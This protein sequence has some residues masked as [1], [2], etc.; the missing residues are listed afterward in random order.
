MHL[1]LAAGLL[2][3]GED[4]D[5]AR[6]ALT[7]ALTALDRY[8]ADRACS[9]LVKLN[10][11]RS[12]DVLIAA[13]R[14]GVLQL[15]EFE[16]ERTRLR[17][18]LEKAEPVKDKDGKILKAGDPFKAK[19][20]QRDIDIVAGK[21]DVLNGALPRAVSHIGKLTTLKE[22]VVALN[23]TPEWY[24]RACCAEALGRLDQP[25]ALAALLARAAKEVEP[26]VRIAIAD[27]L[28][29]HT[30]KNEE[31]RKA[32][33]PWVE[34]GTWASR[35]AA[36]QALTQSGDKKLIPILIKMLGSLTGGRMKHEINDC[37]RK[38]TG[39]SRHGE[40]AAWQAWWEKHENEVLAGTYVP[41]LA[42]RVEGPNLTQ[43]YGI[44][45]HST[46][47]V[48]IIDSSL[49]MKE[50]TTWKPEIQDNSQRLEGERAIDVARYE[51]R[52]I[53]KALPENS[54]FDIIAMYGRLNLLSEKWVVASSAARERAL[55]FVDGLE[56]KVGTD[57]HGALMRALDFS[58][59]TWNTPPREESIDTIFIL[60]DGMPSVGLQDRS[61]IPDRILDAA[62]FKRIAIT[63][64][65][66]AAPKEGR[67]ILKKI[68]EGS[69]GLFVPR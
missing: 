3:Q 7:K 5:K 47:V 53:I 56:I 61:Q 40:P 46:K 6:D 38:L 27:A 58:G 33:L 59:G 54:L 44:P 14:A 34:G 30:A 48:F 21:I 49:S 12:V 66:I 55:K 37:L 45:L 22:I 36:A 24:P 19:I 41:S 11:E 13:F 32:L 4:V 8:A 17:S 62:R 15:A 57:V 60:S 18:D 2:L 16:K 68:S 1:L 23:N 9:T 52:K 63:A 50:P 42:D 51:L 43:F 25:E 65:A 26:G 31:A 39:V 35:L 20:L 69:G 29:P 67:E 64:I 28:A 10:H